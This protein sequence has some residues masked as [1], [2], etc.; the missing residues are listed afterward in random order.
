MSRKAQMIRL[1]ISTTKSIYIAS[2]ILYT[3]GKTMIRKDSGQI[4]AAEVILAS[5][6]FMSAMNFANG[7][8][9]TS[10]PPTYSM[11]QY[12]TLGE[13]A[14]RT[15]DNIPLEDANESLRYHDSTLTKY[16]ATN[17]VSNLTAFLNATIPDTHSYNIFV[18]DAPFYV[19]GT[20]VGETATSHYIIVID[21]NVLDVRMQIWYEVRG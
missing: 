17:D 10:Y 6:I 11:N 21:G 14:L 1:S 12:E 9:V 15:L 19:M 4:H 18:N 3:I 5:V 16:I 13:D 2:N 20:A 7:L 8:A